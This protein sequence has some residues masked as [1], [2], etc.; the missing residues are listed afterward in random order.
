MENLP[1]KGVTYSK[2]LVK[3]IIDCNSLHDAKQTFSDA[4]TMMWRCCGAN[5]E[6]WSFEEALLKNT[7]G[8]FTN[9]KCNHDDETTL[10]VKNKSNNNW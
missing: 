2:K 9:L 4:V 10:L 8:F 7:V 5:F 3:G 1:G 6:I